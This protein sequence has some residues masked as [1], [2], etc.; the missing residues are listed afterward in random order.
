MI[1]KLENIKNWWLSID[2]WIF[3][4]SLLLIFI[5]F[6]LILSS[7][8]S[9]EN[10]YDLSD[11]YLIKKHI[12]FIPI[13]IFIILTTSN[14]SVRNLIKFSIIIFIISLILSY[15]P[16]ILDREIQGAKRWIKLYFITIQPTEFLKPS[17]AIF[18][19][20]LLSRFHKK[21]DYSLMFNFF[22]FF[23]IGLSLILQP[24]FGMLI[25]IFL[26]WLPQIIISGISIKVV[27]LIILVGFLTSVFAFFRYDQISFRLKNYFYNEF[28]DNYQ[29]KKSLEAISNG[30][31]FGKGLGSGKVSERLPDA[32]SDFIFALAGEELGLFFLIF[33]I[34]IYLLIFYRVIISI[35]REK[36]LFVFIACSG[37]I[38]V[39]INQCI[40]NICSS[41]NLIPTKGMTL[42]FLSYGGSSYLSCSLVIGFILCL[43][44]KFNLNEK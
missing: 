27:A 34:I 3:L 38:L 35:I 40:I 43:T 1:I 11:G 25:L 15:I 32:H 10:R 6:F 9:Y 30:G 44:K 12:F 4:L 14:L 21:K 29:I 19:A 36:N 16:I 26:M 28:G 7:S 2:K 22:I 33:I 24:D 39:F 8:S 41:I 42:P 5:G 17:F 18:S 13:S 20:L 31:F 23:L 37:L